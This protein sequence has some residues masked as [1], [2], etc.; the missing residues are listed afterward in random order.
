MGGALQRP[1]RIRA[2]EIG[3][4]RIEWFGL[5]RSGRIPGR[6]QRFHNLDTFRSNGYLG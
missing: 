6:P 3:K 2:V 5:S 1:V 4:I